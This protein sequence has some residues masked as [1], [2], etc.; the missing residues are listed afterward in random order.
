MRLSRVVRLLGVVRGYWEERR[1][2]RFEAIQPSVK[3]GL[4]VQKASHKKPK[5]FV[6]VPTKPHDHRSRPLIPIL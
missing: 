5:D 1:G 6:S 3:Y 4:P 2:S